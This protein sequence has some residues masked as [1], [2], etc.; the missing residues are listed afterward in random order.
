M[1]ILFL[2]TLHHGNSFPEQ[3]IGLAK[4]NNRRQE[5]SVENILQN[6]YAS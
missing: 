2:D 5:Q 6:I 3:K 4:I 1:R